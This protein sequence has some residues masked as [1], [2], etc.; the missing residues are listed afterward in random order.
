MVGMMFNKEGR[1]SGPARPRAATFVLGIESCRGKERQMLMKHWQCWEGGP[2]RCS[3][4]GVLLSSPFGKRLFSRVVAGTWGIF[5]SYS[6]DVH[7]K[8]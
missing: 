1:E 8:L 4:Y 7:S 5:S 2:G 6:G 3:G